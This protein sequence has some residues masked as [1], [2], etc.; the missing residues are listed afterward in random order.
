MKARVSLQARVNDGTKSFP[1]LPVEIKRRMILL[2]VEREKDGRFF[3]LKDIIG[4]YARYPENGKRKVQPLGK[5]PV[6]AY[7]QFQQIEQNFARTQ[8]GLL[9]LNPPEPKPESK[10]DR[11]IKACAAEY[12]ADKKTLGLKPTSLSK[13]TSA[14][15]DFVALYTKTKR[16][17]DE[18]NRKDIMDYIAWMR[19]NLRFQKKGDRQHVIKQRV[20]YVSA[21]LRRFEVKPPIQQKEIK[22][23]VKTRPWRYSEDVLNLLLSKA[24]RD[25]KDLIHFLV[26]TGFRDEETEYVKWSDIDLQV[27]SINVTP[28]SEYGWTPKD[29]ESREQDIVLDPKFVKLMKER[30]ERMHG[31]DSDIIFPAVKTGRPDGHLINRVRKAAKAI[32]FD[33]SKIE[34]HAFRRTFGSIVA[35]HRGIEQARIWLGHSD[36]ATTQRYIAADEM[37]TE[38][39]RKIAKQMFAGIGD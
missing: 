34:L 13:Y 30:K 1:Q 22:K 36:I 32:G 28:N 29:G 6:A 24:T 31:K 7:T 19:S 4:F 25:Q 23:P 8:E 17:I 26:N 39:A 14:L 12:L 9:P 20:Q 38:H 37:T 27:G 21:L 2:P 35:K 5:D 3:D 15:R 10:G 33:I 18:V 11:D 16:S